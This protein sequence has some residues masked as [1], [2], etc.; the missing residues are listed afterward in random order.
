MWTVC[1]EEGV[2]GLI[3]TGEGGLDLFEFEEVSVD[4]IGGE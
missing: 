3:G 1:G 2:W 4:M